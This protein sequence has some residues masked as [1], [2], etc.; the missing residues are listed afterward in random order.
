M[1]EFY[2]TRQFN[3]HCLEIMREAIHQYVASDDFDPEVY[4][5][6]MQEYFNAAAIYDGLN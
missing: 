6:M 2:K 1:C 4:K 5:D 3:K